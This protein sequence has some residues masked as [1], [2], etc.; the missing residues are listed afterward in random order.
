VRRG[1]LKRLLRRIVLAV[2]AV[3]GILAYERY[4]LPPSAA[5]LDRL[6]EERREL[7]RR[8]GPRLASE[9]QGMPAEA[10]VVLGIPPRFAERLAQEVAPGVLQEMKVHF[11]NIEVTKSGEL[12]ARIL[13]GHQQLGA[14][15]LRL[16]LDDVDIVLR[17]GKPQVRFDNGRVAV[18]LPVSLASGTGRGNIRFE[19]DGRGLAGGVC[20]D[21]DLHGDI[22]GNV[23]PGEHV[24]SGTLALSTAGSALVAQPELDDVELKL[25]IE[26]SAET[27]QLVDKAMQERG[28]MCRTA[29][30]TADVPEKIRAFVNRGF[31]VALPKRLLRQV[32]FPAAMEQQVDVEGQS[33]HFQVRPTAVTVTPARLWYGAEVTL[34]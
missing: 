8:L 30:R 34:Q 4:G 31:T 9:L 25:R 3:A 12:Q 33:L 28:A 20:G 17:A 5:D 27:W 6:R 16:H 18:S 26:P 21:M 2:I 10:S 15:T 22:A 7:S 24:L 19:W 1:I 13:I 32:R 29:L 23:V 11:R 14:F